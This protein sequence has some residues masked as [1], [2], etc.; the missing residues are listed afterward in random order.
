MFHA[1]SGNAGS[2]DDYGIVPW[3]GISAG[4]PSQLYARN[5][6]TFTFDLDVTISES[7][8]SNVSVSYGSDGQTV[9]AAVPEPAGLAV[10]AVG[11]LGLL[12]RTR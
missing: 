7:D 12:R 10:V 3:A 6:M 5:S 1:T 4:N 8:F 11:I 9:L 2:N